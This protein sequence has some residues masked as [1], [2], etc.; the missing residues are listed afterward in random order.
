MNEN[1]LDIIYGIHP[2][3]EALRSKKRNVTQLYV[4]DSKAGHRAIEDIIRLAKRANVKIDRIDNKTLDRLTRNANHQG[5]MA[6]IQPVRLMKLSNA[7]YES[8]RRNDRPA[9][10]RRDYP[11]CGLFGGFHYYPA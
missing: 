3:Q 9:K 1:N 2:V 5:I 7:I 6:K 10:L 11:Q 8:R 4:S